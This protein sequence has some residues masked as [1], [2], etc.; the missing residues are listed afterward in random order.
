MN[1]RWQPTATIRLKE[2]DIC[3]GSKGDCH[4]YIDQINL[5]RSKITNAELKMLTTFQNLKD[6]SL[7]QTQISDEGLHYL[8]KLSKLEWLNLFKSQVSD[9]GMAQLIKLESLQYLPIG[10]TKVTD[11]G[12]I[13]IKKIKSLNNPNIEGVIIGKSIYDGDI[14]INELAKQI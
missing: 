10:K 9:G 6:L 4:L 2:K 8:S 14:K 7:E 12:L 3:T 5:N 1:N 11:T 13:H